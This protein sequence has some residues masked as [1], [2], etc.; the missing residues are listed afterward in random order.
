MMWDVSQI[1]VVF[2][3]CPREPS[4]LAQTLASFALADARSAQF[5]AVAVSVDAEGLEC[6]GELVGLERLRWRARTV[7]ESKAV[8]EYH[9]HRRACANYARALDLGAAAGARGVLVCEDDVVFRDGWVGMLL[10]SLNEMQG[11]GLGEFILSLYSAGEHEG[12]LR[13]GRFYSSYPADCFFGTQAVFFSAGELAPVRGIVWDC[14]VVS[15][16]APYDLLIRRRTVAM[17]HLYTTRCSLVQ[18]IGGVSTGLSCALHR[19]P[20]FERAWPER[21]G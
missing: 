16:E 11:A 14:G 17:Q 20:T 8:A 19:S 9:V 10:D 2:L 7:E 12:S 18:H 21:E 1:A 4:Y 3:T 6:G 13:R 5:H 15:P